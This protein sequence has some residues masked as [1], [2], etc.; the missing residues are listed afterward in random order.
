VESFYNAMRNQ[1]QSSGQSNDTLARRTKVNWLAFPF[2]HCE[3]I[4][5]EGVR[6]YLEGD[7]NIKAHRVNSFSRAKKYDCS[8]VIDRVHAERGH[9]P[10]LAVD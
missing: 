10:F 9:C 5:K 7:D 2:K 3:K 4:I 1:Q 6:L 8:K